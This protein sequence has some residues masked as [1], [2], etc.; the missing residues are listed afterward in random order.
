MNEGNPVPAPAPTPAPAAAPAAGKTIDKNLH[1]W[2]WCFLLGGFGLD[3]FMR[4]QIG[5]GVAKL[6]FGWC[7]MGLWALIDWIIAL[8]KAYGSSYK[9]DKEFTFGPDGKYLK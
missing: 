3:R 1:T 2:V 7:T 6:L 8:S 4:G 5:L 9:D